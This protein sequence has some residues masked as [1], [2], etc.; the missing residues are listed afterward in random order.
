MPQPIPQITP[1]DLSP[2]EAH[3]LEQALSAG[4][5]VKGTTSPNP[6]VGA[7][8]LSAE[9]ELCGIGGTQ[10]AGGPHAEIMALAEAGPRARGGTAIVT[11]EPC[12]HT[13][14][15][16]PCTR[17]LREAGIAKVI[18]LHADPMREAAGGAQELQSHGIQ[19]Q[20]LQLEVPELQPWL[21]S[22]RLGRPHITLK[23]AQT[24]DGF[25]SAADGS[26][27]WITGPA[28]RENVHQDRRTRDAI[29]IGTGTALA[30]NPSLTARTP[31]GELYPEQPLRIVIGS[32][33][34]TKLMPQGNLAEL[35]FLQFPDIQSMLSESESL[36]LRDVLV[37][38][39]PRLAGSFLQARV[40]DALRVYIAPKLF[41]AG[42]PSTLGAGVSTLADAHEFELQSTTVLGEDILALYRRRTSS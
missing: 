10:P 14:R 27:Q 8:I 41:G 33:P 17:A 2:A 36:G 3:A 40:V 15:T 24:L 4:A 32:R 1:G 22:V 42:T 7:A 29:I 18:F 39:G 28:A 35:G 37:E 13:G 34:I 31:G 19:V 21:S 16:G 6:A 23:I 9:A 25:T 38:G 20:Q 11:L 26:S 5:Q 12:R 30:D